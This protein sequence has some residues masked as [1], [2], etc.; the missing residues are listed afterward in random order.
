TWT[1]QTGQS[2]T[3][4][5]TLVKNAPN[6]PGAILFLEYLLDPA[7]GLKVLEEMGQPIIAPSQVVSDEVLK[8]LPGRLPTLVEVKK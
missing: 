4:G 2:S 3:Y 5:V 6:R 7:G 1:T 8:A